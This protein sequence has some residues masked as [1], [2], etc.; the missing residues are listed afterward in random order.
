MVE[1]WR[2]DRCRSGP[3]SLSLGE[4]EHPDD[5]QLDQLALELIRWREEELS[6]A[7]AKALLAR[8]LK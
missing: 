1:P 8:S 4:D 3:S 5:L 6:G 7:E 2:N